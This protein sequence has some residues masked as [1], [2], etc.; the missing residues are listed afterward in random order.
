MDAPDVNLVYFNLIVFHNLC[1]A[2]MQLVF[3][4]RNQYYH[5][6]T[7]DV[8]SETIEQE[9]FCF[10]GES[11]IQLCSSYFNTGIQMKQMK[12]TCCS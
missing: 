3:I 4:F 11:L 8:S 1:T 5:P 9:P 7:I 6:V 2:D 12:I 10:V